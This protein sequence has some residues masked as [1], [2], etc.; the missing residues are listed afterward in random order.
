MSK[1]DWVTILKLSEG[2][3]TY[4][5]SCPFEDLEEFYEIREFLNQMEENYKDQYDEL[6][7]TLR[8]KSFGYG[9]VNYWFELQGRYTDPKKIVLY[10][11]KVQD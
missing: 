10:G 11:N 3:E 4:Q 6:R 5:P 8:S 7:I 1:S 9:A 2:D